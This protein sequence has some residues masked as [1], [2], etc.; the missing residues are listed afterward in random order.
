MK[1][2]PPLTRLRPGRACTTAGANLGKLET[3]IALGHLSRRY[4]Q[5]RLAPG[6]QFS[7]HPNISFR[8][9]QA[10]MVRAAPYRG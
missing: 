9:P 2:A 1:F 8:G 6:Q 10:L 3:Q 5:L 7:F 4:P